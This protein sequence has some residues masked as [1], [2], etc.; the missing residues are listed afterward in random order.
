MEMIL[1]CD[2]AVAPCRNE[3]LIEKL[4][5]QRDALLEACKAFVEYGDTRWRIEYCVPA[6]QDIFTQS[7]A[8]IKKV[9]SDK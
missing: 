2:G 1:E 4:R 3:H 6:M 9:T 7:R 8:A 5:A